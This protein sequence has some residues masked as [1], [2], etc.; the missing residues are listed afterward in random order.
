MVKRRDARSLAIRKIARL[1]FEP[2]LTES[3]S[4]VL[5]LHYQAMMNQNKGN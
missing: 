5:P 1:G 3:E 4:V 2:R